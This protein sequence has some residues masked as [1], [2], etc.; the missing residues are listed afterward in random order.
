MNSYNTSFSS[1]DYQAKHVKGYETAG[2]WLRFF[3]DF[4]DRLIIGFVTIAVFFATILVVGSSITN[5]LQSNSIHNSNN[6]FS[7]GDLSILSTGLILTILAISIA[8]TL[9]TIL[10]G[11]FFESSR[12]CCTPGKMLL[13][14][15]VVDHQGQRLSFSHAFQRNLYKHIWMGIMLGSVIISIISMITA[16]PT[17]L[18]AL[19]MIVGPIVGGIVYIVGYLMAAFTVDNQAWHDKL[20]ITYVEKDINTSNIRRAVLIALA[21][22]LMVSGTI[23]NYTHKAKPSY[24]NSSWRVISK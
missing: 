15:Y 22:L 9:I 16:G 8:P 13:G 20:A 14:I 24:Q 23:V 1:L 4:Y 11:A 5:I 19:I 6:Y 12:W 10:Y 3:A 17:I 18:N 7:L 21:T 2:F